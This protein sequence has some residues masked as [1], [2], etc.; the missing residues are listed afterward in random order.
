M[1]TNTELLGEILTKTGGDINN[2]PDNLKTTILKQIAENLG[3][4]V[5]TLPDNLETTLLKVIGEN[6]GKVGGGDNAV[7]DVAELPTENIEEGKIYR[8][9]KE[10]E[11]AVYTAF[12]ANNG[13][14]MIMTFADMFEA[15]LGEKINVLT[16]VAESLPD[17]MEPIDYGTPMTIPC[18]VLEST[19]VPYVST[20]GTSA[21]AAPLSAM[22]DGFVDK[23][24]VNSVEDM[25]VGDVSA[26]YTLRGGF[27]TTYGIPNNATVKRL[28]DGA[29][30]NLA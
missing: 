25:V 21:S 29:W 16:Q 3:V 6:I 26:V 19:G 14:P 30:V 7:I 8:V 24:W 2:L 13:S 22:L 1:S 18:Y 11:T 5:S 9:T 23:G 10:A 27:S 4:D 28:V 12:I 17:A 20:D 15:E